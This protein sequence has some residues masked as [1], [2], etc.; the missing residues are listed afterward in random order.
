M[1][2]AIIAAILFISLVVNAPTSIGFEGDAYRIKTSKFSM[3]EL[4]AR[5]ARNPNDADAL[6]ERGQVYLSGGECDLA[7]ADY[8]ACLKLAP[9][10]A[11]ALVG[12]SQ[13]NEMEGHHQLALQDL[14]QVIASKD[15][16]ALAEAYKNKIAVL[17]S[18]KRYSETPELYGKL[19]ES[20]G[21]GVGRFDR[22]VLHEERADM[23]LIIGKPLLAIEDI[24]SCEKDERRHYWKYLLLGKAYGQLKKPEQELKA[25]SAGIKLAEDANLA[26]IGFNNR[27]AEL[28]RAR[29]DLYA[30]MG[31]PALAKADMQV[32]VKMQ[33]GIY[34]NFYTRKGRLF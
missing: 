13:A 2:T 33:D 15:P 19:L 20:K 8:T 25:Y 12:R 16:S 10:T 26:H 7:I 30:R 22:Y 6:L 3:K 14:E 34:K 18:L 31:K 4:D 5:L 11:R 28:Y 9:R 24:K 29:A 17:K 21:L 27:L 32:L 23:Y 1:K